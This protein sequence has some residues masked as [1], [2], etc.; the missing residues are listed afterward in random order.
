MHNSTTVT[1]GVDIISRCTPDSTQVHG[2]VET[3]IT[4]VLTIVVKEIALRTDDEEVI[5]S[6]A[7]YTIEHGIG[8]SGILQLTHQRSPLLAIVVK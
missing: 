1:Y 7:P 6:A 2:C 5:F 4:P 8:G 3:H